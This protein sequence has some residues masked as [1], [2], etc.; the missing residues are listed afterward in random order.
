MESL[1]MPDLRAT[2]RKRAILGFPEGGPPRYEV[3]AGL[4]RQAI[5]EGASDERLWLRSVLIRGSLDL[6]TCAVSSR[7]VFEDCQFVGPLHI[8]QAQVP[9]VIFNGCEFHETVQAHQLETRWNLNLAGSVLQHGLKLDRAVVGGDLVMTGMSVR[10]H[11]DSSSAL[12]LG[13]TGISVAGG[14]FLMGTRV[15]GGLAMTGATVDG[16]VSLNAAHIKVPNGAGT[17]LHGDGISVGRGLFCKG[18]EISGELRLPGATIG[19]QLVLEDGKLE[20]YLQPGLPGRA[21]NANG[22]D[23]GTDLFLRRLR[24]SGGV[25]VISG[26]IDEQLSLSD[27]R[28]EGPEPSGSSFNGDHLEVGASAML[29]NMEVEGEV[30]MLE[31]RIGGQLALGATRITVAG[32]RGLTDALSVDGITVADSFRLENTRI[33]GAVRLPGAKVGGILYLRSADLR[34][35]SGGPICIEAE[36]CVLGGGVYGPRLSARGEIKLVG[37]RLEGEANFSHAIL[38]ARPVQSTTLNLDRADCSGGLVLNAVSSMGVL[39][40]SGARVGLGLAL[41]QAQLISLKEIGTEGVALDGDRIGVRGGVNAEGL[42]SVGEVR[43]RGGNIEGQLS[44]IGGRMESR[45]GASTSLH[46]LNL[47]GLDLREDLLCFGLRTSGSLGLMSMKVGGRL[48]LDDAHLEASGDSSV[49]LFGDGIQVT[50]GMY[51]IR[52]R[53]FGQVRLP[54]AE[55]SG[56]LQIY[57]SELTD[58]GNGLALSLAGAKMEDLVLAPAWVTGTVDLRFASVRALWDAVGEEFLGQA[59]KQLWLDG[60][61]YQYLRDPLPAYKR[62]AW[63][64][65]SEDGRYVPDIYSELSAAY[66]RV[67]HAADARAVLIAAERQ[68]R[69]Q[70]KRFDLRSIWNDFLWVTVGYGYRNWLAAIWLVALVCLGAL[71]FK[72]GEASFSPLIE[73]PVDFN[74]A[75]YAVD[76][77]V[78][79][80]DLGQQSSWV[81]SGLSA[82]ISLAL[83]VC[84]YGLATAVIAA[85]AGL[86]KRGERT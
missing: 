73:S 6:D 39:S 13:L 56:Q 86:L 77:T 69:E 42:R 9:D 26:K 34:A 5:L 81:P 70:F 12:G 46:A 85:A 20:S 48:S 79:I 43:F 58:G 59:P 72:I 11:S 45:P 63:I 75:L 2:L 32:E 68:A 27:T 29:D 1:T 22:I 67:G 55:L 51:C 33:V 47:E 36:G 65:S 80:L 30:R 50:R 54:D 19:G 61:T 4:L 71:I 44:V 25:Q 84:G 3:Q 18:L 35:A 57:K 62:L 21:F 28:I 60:F 17:A 16:Q 8:R 83:A 78:P 31:A 82:W 7:L 64:G 15:V 40:M 37:S 10:P 41:N 24:I 52:T 66:R 49:S 53:F 74:P 14:L 76:V 23:V 38:E